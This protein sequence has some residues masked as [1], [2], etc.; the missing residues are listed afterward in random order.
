MNATVNATSLI[1]ASSREG[2][3]T[4]A[5][6]LVCCLLQAYLPLQCNFIFRHTS[7]SLDLFFIFFLRHFQPVLQGRETSTVIFPMANFNSLP[8]AI[9]ERIYEL[10]LTQKES[11]TLAQYKEH[12][13]FH[14]HYTRRMPALLQVSRKIEKEAAPFFYAKNDFEFAS[15]ADIHYFAALSWPRHRHLIRRLTVTWSWRALGASEC[16]NRIASMRNLEELYIRVDEEEMLLKMLNKSKFHHNLVFDPRS[17]PQENLAMLRHPGLVGLLKLR[18]P[19]VRFIELVDDGD[20]RGGPIPGGVLE[21]IITP[22]VMGSE[23]TE[24]R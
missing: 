20:M 5:K 23:S 10:H 4:F 14:R 17:T 22:K 3:T 16:F 2:A 7:S 18:V 19:K 13:G 9:R 15:L 8:K 21:T 11:I 1:L 24:K 12:V 6:L